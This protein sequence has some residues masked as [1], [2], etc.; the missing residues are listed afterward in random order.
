MIS[1]IGF[2]DF[3][4]ILAYANILKEATASVLGSK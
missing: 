3:K 1:G 2:Q 4:A